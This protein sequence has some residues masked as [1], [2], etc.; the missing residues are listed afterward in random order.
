MFGI[1]NDRD[2]NRA[3]A[4]KMSGYDGL[5]GF[6]LFG[7]PETGGKWFF[8]PICSSQKPECLKYHGP[9]DE[10]VKFWVLFFNNLLI[11]QSCKSSVLPGTVSTPAGLWIT[12]KS[13]SRWIR[14]SVRKLLNVQ[15]QADR[16]N[17]PAM[18]E[19]LAQNYNAQCCNW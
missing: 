19:S 14:C 11:T 4:F 10:S 7:V 8:V 18:I 9:D 17:K 15:F 2:I 5:I 12:I 6:F 13:S 1:V 16:E 3:F